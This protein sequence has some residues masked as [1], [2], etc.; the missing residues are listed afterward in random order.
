MGAWGGTW[1]GD[2]RWGF[3]LHL[4]PSSSNQWN[5]ISGGGCTKREKK[6]HSGEKVGECRHPRMRDDGGL[7]GDLVGGGCAP[8]RGRQGAARHQTGQYG[9]VE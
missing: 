6:G 1:A 4:W 3:N 2:G 5:Y 9:K 8:Q 7:K